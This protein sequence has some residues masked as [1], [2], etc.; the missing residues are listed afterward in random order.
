MN[1]IKTSVWCVRYEYSLNDEIY[2]TVTYVNVNPNDVVGAVTK[3]VLD[4]Q[5]VLKSAHGD[6]A[7]FIC[8]MSITEGAA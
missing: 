2:S 5:S 1:Y 7:K 8:I 3:C 6:K 4:C